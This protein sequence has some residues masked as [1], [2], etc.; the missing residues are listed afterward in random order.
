MYTGG[1]F[2]KVNKAVVDF[3]NNILH[4]GDNVVKILNNKDSLSASSEIHS[5]SLWKTWRSLAVQC[6]WLLQLCKK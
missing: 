1:R 2:L 6:F 3:R 5:T 4:L